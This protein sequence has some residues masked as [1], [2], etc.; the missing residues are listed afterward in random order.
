MVVLLRQQQLGL[1]H[2]F[3]VQKKIIKFD[4]EIQ[5][6]RGDLYGKLVVYVRKRKRE[7]DAHLSASG[8]QQD[9]G[10]D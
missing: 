7:L 3:S 10:A 6:L 4:Q 5:D 8:T 2:V 1:K 9:F